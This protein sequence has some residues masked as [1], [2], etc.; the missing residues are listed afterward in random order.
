[1]HP[2]VRAHASRLTTANPHSRGRPVRGRHFLFSDIAASKTLS[3]EWDA[4]ARSAFSQ[5]STS[6][7]MVECIAH[8]EG[9]RDNV[10]A[11]ANHG[12]TPGSHGAGRRRGR[13]VRAAIAMVRGLANDVARSGQSSAVIDGRNGHLGSIP[14]WSRRNIAGEAHGLYGVGGWRVNLARDLEAPARVPRRRFLISEI[15]SPIAG[16][17]SHRGI[18]R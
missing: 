18:D 2:R 4:K 7:V 14:T 9:M 6:L 3:E 17:L 11:D 8:E 1:M 15:H 13:A 16:D 5:R 12:Q 10:S